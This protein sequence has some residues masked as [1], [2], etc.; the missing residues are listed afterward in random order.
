MRSTRQAFTLVELLVVIAIIGIL[1]ALLLPAIQAARESA[2]RTEC[3]NNLRNIGIAYQNHES[4]NKFFPTGGWGWLWTG[5][6]D[7]GYDVAQPG[8]WAYNILDYTE[9]KNIRQ[10]GKSLT[11][12]AKNNANT[13]AIKSSVP[14][15]LCP[16]RRTKTV[17]PNK[18]G[19][20]RNWNNTP[21]VAR[22]DYASNA[23][24]RSENQ[25]GDGP[26]SLNDAENFF[27]NNWRDTQTK[28]DGLSYVRSRVRTKAITDGLSKTIAVGEKYLDPR[29]YE[30]GDDGAD[31]EHCFTG[32]NNDM[33]RT[34]NNKAESDPVSDYSI[35][36]GNPY[37]RFGGPHT[38]SWNC[39][40]ADAATIQLSF[41]TNFNV[42]KALAGRADGKIFTLP[43]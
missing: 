21:L 7:R 28:S 22:S 13:E 1:V 36:S 14:L 37:N 10:L 19:G 29:Y 32:W 17:F 39:V 11:G 42:I 23:G 41:E 12:A 30:T 35:F 40:L 2:R 16:T 18:L 31:N 27:K 9:A 4:A 6:A 34:V 24:T 8:G 25:S 3:L 15:Y 33:Y 38:S 5:D 26:G 20:G 43:K